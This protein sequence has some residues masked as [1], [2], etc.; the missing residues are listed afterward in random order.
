MSQ[1]A[2]QFDDI[3]ARCRSLFARKTADYGAA[4]TILRLPSLTDQIFIKAKRIRTLEVKGQSLV[5]E[6]IADEYVGIINYCVMALILCRHPELAPQGDDLKPLQAPTDEVLALYDE[7]VAAIRATLLKKNHDYGEAW[8]D[9]RPTS[10]TDLILMKLLRIKQIED[11]EGRT[12]VSEGVDAGYEDMVNYS[13]FALIQ[14][15]EV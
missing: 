1:T 14:L 2:Q 5:G 6:G 9:M 3:V 13:V 10:F 8:R 7:Q 11:N 12:Q 4:W 15:S